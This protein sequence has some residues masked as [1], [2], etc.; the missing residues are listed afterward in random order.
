MGIQQQ[1]HFMYSLKSSSGASKSGA[2]QMVPGRLPACVCRRGWG[3]A[4]ESLA[5]GS[6]FFRYV[7]L[8]K[9]TKGTKGCRLIHSGIGFAVSITSWFRVRHAD[10]LSNS[11]RSSHNHTST[12]IVLFR[13]SIAIKPEPKKSN[14]QILA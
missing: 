3:T 6:P 2:I 14:S 1:L 8:Q 7:F 11:A 4:A 13:P 9:L 10:N 5:F 12:P